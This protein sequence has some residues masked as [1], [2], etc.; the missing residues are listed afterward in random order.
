MNRAEELERIRQVREGGPLAEMAAKRLIEASLSLVVSIAR[1]YQGN[2]TLP[3]L[4]LIQ[5]G[6]LGVESA[7]RA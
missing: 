5:E 4:N 7:I 1:R 6:N 2:A 3:L